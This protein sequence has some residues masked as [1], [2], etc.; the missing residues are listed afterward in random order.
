MAPLTLAEAATQQALAEGFAGGP[1][2][3]LNPVNVS[4]QASIG[5]PLTPI[6]EPAPYYPPAT[7][8]T[9]NLGLSLQ[10]LSV[11]EAN[12]MVILDNSV[13]SG[14]GSVLRAA[15]TLTSAQILALNTTAVQLIPT[16]GAGNFINVISVT[17][18]YQFKGTPYSV[19]G[20]QLN[21][22]TP[23]GIP[24]GDYLFVSSSTGIL[25]G[26]NSS[27]NILQNAISSNPMSEFT[28]QPVVIKSTAPLTVGN[29][30]LQLILIYTIE[31]A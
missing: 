21:V 28:N 24:L 2:P 14:S 29:G 30:T 5:N 27:L 25:D 18:E 9:P 22:S 26:S 6:V 11:V 23:L 13:G 12:N 7:A 4:T 31:T 16:P 19:G 17:A 10:D 20:S 3:T 15:V 8:V 1:L